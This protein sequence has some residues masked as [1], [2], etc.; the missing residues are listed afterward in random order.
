[1]KHVNYSR[2]GSSLALVSL[3]SIQ[4]AP[5]EDQ[6]IALDLLNYNGCGQD[7]L[8]LNVLQDH[9]LLDRD[10]FFGQFQ[11]KLKKI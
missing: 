4:T 2:R 11:D 9:L 7:A 10:F 5:P 6:R 8:L 3:I 1:M